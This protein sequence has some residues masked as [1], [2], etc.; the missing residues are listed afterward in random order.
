[1]TTGRNVKNYL[2]LSENLRSNI[3][4]IGDL[5]EG[6]DYWTSVSFEGGEIY[7][8]LSDPLDNYGSVGGRICTNKK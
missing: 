5:K 6:L 7:V 1:M 8:E 2:L 3:V 4:Q